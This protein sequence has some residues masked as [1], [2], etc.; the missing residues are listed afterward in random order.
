MSHSFYGNP[1]NRGE[2]ERFNNNGTKLGALTV[3]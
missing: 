1:F 3:L 2:K